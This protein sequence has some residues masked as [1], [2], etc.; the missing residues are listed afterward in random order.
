MA[1]PQSAYKALQVNTRL[2]IE[3]GMDVQE[4]ADKL[5]ERGIINEGERRRATD[6]LCGMT[7]EERLGRLLEVIRASVKL[8]GNV[9]DQFINILE[10]NDSVR[11]ITLANKLKEGKLTYVNHYLLAFSFIL[12]L[13]LFFFPSH[14]SHV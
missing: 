13:S 2:I 9:F 3:A 6:R 14:C 7:A 11:M 1:N 10:E 12:I 4:L 8:N 5:L